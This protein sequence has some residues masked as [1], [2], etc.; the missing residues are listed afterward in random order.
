MEFPHFP[1]SGAKRHRGRSPMTKI[2]RPGGVTRLDVP[3]AA[4]LIGQN[5]L[6]GEGADWNRMRRR[7]RKRSRLLQQ[8]RNVQPRNLPEGES[9]RR[10]HLPRAV[11]AELSRRGREHEVW[12][13]SPPKERLFRV[14]PWHHE[15]V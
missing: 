9:G 10:S 8:S 4:Q 6:N 5:R 7:V 11:S 15:Q 1:E 2:D 3:S 13:D 12:S 14:R